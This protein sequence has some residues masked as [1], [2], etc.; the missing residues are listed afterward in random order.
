M[1]GRSWFPP[2]ATPG[3]GK[4]DE[5][6]DKTTDDNLNPEIKIVKETKDFIFNM[7]MKDLAE[8]GLTPEQWEII[9]SPEKLESTIRKIV[10]KKLQEDGASA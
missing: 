9:L 7:D 8:L 2:E 10:R 6:V 3:V 5:A 4:P 1:G